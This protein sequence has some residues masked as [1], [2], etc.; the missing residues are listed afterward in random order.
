[1]A[2]ALLPLCCMLGPASVRMDD[3]YGVSLRVFSL[4]FSIRSGPQALTDCVTLVEHSY[5]SFDYTLYMLTPP[6]LLN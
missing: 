1:M 3:S 2:A 4:F 5:T 6:S